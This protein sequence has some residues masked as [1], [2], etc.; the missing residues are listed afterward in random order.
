MTELVDW[1]RAEL[2]ADREAIGEKTAV[3]WAITAVDTALALGL[4]ARAMIHSVIYAVNHGDADAETE[5]GFSMAEPALWGERWRFIDRLQAGLLG[6]I[7]VGWVIAA[8]EFA[9]MPAAWLVYLAA[10]AAVLVFDPV[11]AVLW[12]VRG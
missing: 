9:A 2:Q 3:D 7:V 11:V 8:H 10:N 12:E 4:L 5:I 1:L 6:P